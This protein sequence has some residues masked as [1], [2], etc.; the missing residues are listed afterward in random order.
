MILLN[1]VIIDDWPDFN[2]ERLLRLKKFGN[3]TWHKV[4]MLPQ[5]KFIEL[6]KDAEILMTSHYAVSKITKEMM[7]KMPSLKMIAQL[8]TGYDYLDLKAATEKQIVV[9][10]V[11]GYGDSSVAE[12]ALG[13]MLA[14]SKKIF[15]GACQMKYEKKYEFRENKGFELNGKTLGLIGYGHT[16]GALGV[17]AKG[18]GMRVIAFDKRI[19]SEVESVDFETILKQ[20]D[21]ISLHVPLTDETR[22][23]L[24]MNEFRKMKKN[25]LIINT[26]RAPIV[27]QE[28]LLKA[29]KENLIGGYAG[30]LV[31]EPFNAK[32]PLLQQQNAV[33]TPHI[34]WYT[35]EAVAR[36][37]EIAVRNVEAFAAGKPTNVVNK[38]S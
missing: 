37:T 25:A 10:N 34:A 1:I 16:G 26:A 31:I 29:L 8:A 12:H 15:N 32:D 21:V 3:V 4:Q 9:C 33:F 30:D 17:I 35:N 19:P 36:L 7:D 20:S 18:L 22:N 28:D 38:R 27:N 13:L 6:A 14:L 23:M 5:E 24:S 2:N 11:P